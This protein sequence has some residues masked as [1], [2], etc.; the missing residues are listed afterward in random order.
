M[1]R[2]RKIES[3]EQK[4]DPRDVD[5]ETRQRYMTAEIRLQL[6]PQHPH[7]LHDEL[8]RKAD[9][10]NARAAPLKAAVRLLGEAEACACIWNHGSQPLVGPS[11]K[12]GKI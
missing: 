8:L 9:S 4:K 12:E 5:G 3:R 11:A 2:G 6:Q 1:D 10:A 7:R